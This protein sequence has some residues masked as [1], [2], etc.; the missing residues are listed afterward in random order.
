MLGGRGDGAALRTW[1]Q[2]SLRPSASAGARARARAGKAPAAAA[3]S[4]CTTR[5]PRSR[6]NLCAPGAAVGPLAAASRSDRKLEPATHLSQTLQSPDRYCGRHSTFWDEGVVYQPSKRGVWSL[7]ATNTNLG[8]D[9]RCLHDVLNA[10]LQGVKK[11]ARVGQHMSCIIWKVWGRAA[12]GV[13]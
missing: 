6:T 10:A 9:P 11:I 2:L 3:T 8:T 1:G 13:R 4:A 12:G 5:W 7:D